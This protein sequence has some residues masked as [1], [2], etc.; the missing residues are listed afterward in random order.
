MNY[1]SEFEVYSMAADPGKVIRLNTDT[2]RAFLKIAPAFNG[3]CE[4][5]PVPRREYGRIFP[6]ELHHVNDCFN[7]HRRRRLSVT[8]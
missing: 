5:R 8:K 6:V 7:A 1:K 2:L 3:G 4:F